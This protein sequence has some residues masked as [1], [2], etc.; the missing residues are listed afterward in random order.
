M[1]V[2]CPFCGAKYE[3]PPGRRFYVCPYCGTALSGG[4]AYDDV[5]IFRPAVDKT[6]AFKAVLNFRP[7]AAPE[8]LSTATPAEA[9]LHFLPLYLY[10]VSFPPLDQLATYATAL[11]TSSPPVPL[12]KGFR[13]PARWRTPFKPTLEKLGTFHSPDLD[14]EAAF[15]SLQEVVEEVRTYAHVFRV[16]V[17]VRHR[18]EGLV[19]HPVWRLAY[20]YRG[21][22][23][24][25]AV[26]ATD[27]T[28]LYMEYPISARGRAEALGM[29]VATV[30]GAAALGAAVAVVYAGLTPILGAVGGGIAS[31][32]AAARLVR[33]IAV[34]RVGKYKAEARL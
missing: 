33:N 28:V 26:D 21:R 20:D 13:F 12:P 29:A 31:L 4:K 34:A 1:I 3:A 8:D 7:A 17:D 32:G 22:R 9:E 27:G 25:A 30:V 5:Y 15:T 23:Y 6:A 24:S 14:P 11:A 10:Y 2:Q 16:K 18:F 19:Y